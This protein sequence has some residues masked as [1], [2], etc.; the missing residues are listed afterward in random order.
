[1]K[2]LL[3]WAEGLAALVGHV[4]GDGKMI[5][6]QV[7][8]TFGRSTR[9]DSSSPSPSPVKVVAGVLHRAVR[10]LSWL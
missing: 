1:M 5:L 4:D 8:G 2:A 9:I 7:A 6:S 10:L 3:T